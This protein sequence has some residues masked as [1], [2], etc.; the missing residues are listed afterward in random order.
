MAKNT[1]IRGICSV[2]ECQRPHCAKGYCKIH[3][4]RLRRTG[5]LAIT[6]MQRSGRIC[7]V[8]GCGEPVLAQG[9]CRLHYDRLRRR[10]DVG[11]VGR[12]RRARS[13]GDKI[14]NNYGY[15]MVY[16]PDYPGVSRPWY[17]PEHRLVMEQVLGRRLEPFEN[18]HHKNGIRDDNRPENLEVW[19]KPQPNGQRPE[20]LAAWVVEHYADL[21]REALEARGADDDAV[22]PAPEE[23]HRG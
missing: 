18:V 6:Q 3:Y 23:E 11:P 8:D 16:L 21:V 9:L 14:V 2:E 5:H 7:E 22:H 17:V 15:V 1:R 10:G 4:Y 12:T 20:D 19:V 13:V